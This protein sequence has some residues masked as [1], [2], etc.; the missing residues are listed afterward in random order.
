MWFLSAHKT[1][2]ALT[3]GAYLLVNEDN[4]IIDFYIK[5]FTTTSP[6]Y[7][8]MASLDYARYY[9]DTYGKDDYDKLIN[10]SEKWKKKN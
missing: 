1:L 6:S 2:P 7:L 5:L 3:Q 8:I 9:L 10:E 4:D